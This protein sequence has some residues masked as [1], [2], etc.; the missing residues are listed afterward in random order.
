MAHVVVDVEVRIVDP[1]RPAEVTGHPLDHLPVAGDVAELAGD[2]GHQVLD[3]RRRPLEDPDG[4]DVHV[5]DTVLDGQEGR[6]E[7]TQPV[8]HTP[9]AT[10]NPSG[11]P[12]P[13]GPGMA[14][15]TVGLCVNA[16]GPTAP[17]MLSTWSVRESPARP[18]RR[19]SMPAPSLACWW[20]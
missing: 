14:G 5:A 19:A 3:A 12:G 20:R 18:V 11:P 16:P 1:D 6:V 4:R 7:G 17:I 2:H 10:W 15:G 9:N 8:T 13:R